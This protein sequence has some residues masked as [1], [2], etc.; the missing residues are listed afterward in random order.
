MIYSSNLLILTID[1]KQILQEEV[2]AGRLVIVV[3]GPV[4]QLVD[5]NFQNGI[6]SGITFVK[7]YAPW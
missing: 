2:E 3:V 4:V 7:F 6:A 5:S 1:L